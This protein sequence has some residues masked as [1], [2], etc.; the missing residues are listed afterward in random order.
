MCD[1]TDYRQPPCVAV[2]GRLGWRA[3]CLSPVVTGIEAGSGGV[4]CGS[5]AGRPAGRA[6]G[7]WPWSEASLRGEAHQLS[8]QVC[9]PTTTPP[10]LSRPQ[11]GRLVHKG[12]ETCSETVP[13]AAVI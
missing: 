6:R 3:G 9:P 1:T 11:G 2:L 13:E 10:S 5:E 4:L 8:A 12:E 7:W